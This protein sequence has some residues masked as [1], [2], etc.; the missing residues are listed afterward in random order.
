[1]QTKKKAYFIIAGIVALLAIIFIIKL[2]SSASSKRP[3]LKPVVVIGQPVIGDIQ[4]VES[5]TGDVMPDQQANIFSKVNGN[6]EKIY[7]DIG[8]RVS[9]NQKLALI[10]TTIY[11][12][13][14]RQAKANFMQAEASL[15]NAKV[16]YERNKKL[17]E[18][19][20]IAQQDVDNSKAA[21]DV[22]RAQK[23]AAE[24][25][26]NNA[27]TQLGYCKVT[28]PFAGVI[29]KKMFDQ[30][31]YV[32]ASSTTQS[33]SLFTLMSNGKL[34]I[35]VNVPERDIAY[36]SK[37]Q[38]I[39]VKADAVPDREF[40][41]KISK[42]SQAIDLSTRT[43][44]IEIGIDNASGA[45]KPGM[46]ATVNFIT[47]KKSGAKIVPSQVVQNDE[48]GSYVFTVNADSTVSKKYVQTGISMNEKIEIVSGIDDADKLV[49][50]GQTL[51]KDKMK[52]KISK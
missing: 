26:Y 51:I 17:L 43:M 18:Q 24:A 32:T 6:I 4:K 10:D 49:F 50:V 23:Q 39:T 14:A 36:L 42:M 48:K 13:N 29:T 46:F 37:I 9:A 7:V 40:N 30:G 1:M 47:Q 19:K 8:S 33:S 20:M 45:L 21:F 35:D 2:N 31:A 28:A 16:S 41:A 3:V 27:V 34:K 15:L 38:Q 22:A 12:Q 5:L 52:V 25:A 11:S 44:A